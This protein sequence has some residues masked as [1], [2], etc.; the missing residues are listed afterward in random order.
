M[1][2]VGIDPTDNQFGLRTGHPASELRL[3]HCV[4]SESPGDGE[5]QGQDGDDREQGTVGQCR[6]THYNTVV[7]ELD[8][9][10][11]DY[12]KASVGLPLK[13]GDFI[14]SDAPYTVVQKMN[15]RFYSG[16]HGQRV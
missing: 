6:G 3:D 12:F 2:Q 13:V 15:Q 14:F 9:G 8:D 11:I 4:E 7:D 1:L 5:Q 10:E 16:V